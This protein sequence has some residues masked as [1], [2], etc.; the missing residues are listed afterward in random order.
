M[1]A[2][3]VHEAG[4]VLAAKAV[5]KPLSR[6]ERIALRRLKRHLKRTVRG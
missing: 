5:V 3:V 4:I 6:Q 1:K 2:E